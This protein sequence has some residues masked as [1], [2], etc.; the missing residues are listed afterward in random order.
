M[1][2]GRR[3][4]AAAEAAARLPLLVV[5][6]VVPLI[7]FLRAV[8]LDD[9]VAQYWTGA[10]TDY[11]FF[12]YYKAMA[13]VCMAAAAL[14]ALI[15]LRRRID[16]SFPPAVQ[17]A[18]LLLAL[19]AALVLASAL[20]SPYPSIVWKGF[21]GRYEG[22]WVLAS[23]V[24]LVVVSYALFDRPAWLR[25]QAWCLVCSSIVVSAIGL[26]QHAGLDPFRTR[27]GK[28]AILPAALAN[29]IDAVT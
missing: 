24:A 18:L 7:V 22:F 28:T 13:V 26:L 4:R 27:I 19:Y 2:R 12:S 25:T 11:D 23:Y 3:T 6:A 16:G 9:G 15:V 8:P 1:T 29:K 21:V 10:K 14:V 5:L 17:T 20:T